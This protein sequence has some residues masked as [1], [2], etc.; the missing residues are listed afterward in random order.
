MPSYAARSLERV[1]L[2]P[3]A[4][5]HISAYLVAN[6]GDSVVAGE[7]GRLALQGLQGNATLQRITAAPYFKN[8]HRFLENRILDEWVGSVANC[9]ACHV[10]AWVG[11]Y[12]A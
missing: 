11:D 9:P 4:L 3:A 10:G 2:K 1:Q 5:K 12:K 6:A 8:E 7:A